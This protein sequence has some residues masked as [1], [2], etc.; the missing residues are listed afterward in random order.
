[1]GHTAGVVRNNSFWV[2]RRSYYGVGMAEG[3][4]LGGLLGHVYTLD[5]GAAVRIRLARSSDAPAVTALLQRAGR[6][7][8]DFE[9]ARLVH[10]DPRRRYVLCV[11]GLVDSTET[12]LGVGS[13]AREDAAEPGLLVMGGDHAD[14]LRDLLGRALIA[15]AAAHLRAA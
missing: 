2:R 9:V 5:D 13:I 15:S 4:E 14:Q 6:N 11:T 8:A 12:L 3:F 10:F 7:A 1:M